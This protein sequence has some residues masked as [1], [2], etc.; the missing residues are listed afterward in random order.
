MADIPAEEPCKPNK[1][2]KDN[3]IM[4]KDKLIQAIR[5]KRLL[6][7]AE[8]LRRGHN[9]DEIN[10]EKESSRL[11]WMLLSPENN[12]RINFE[13]LIMFVGFMDLFTNIY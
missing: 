11:E 5:L 6:S 12:K 1:S 7:G 2:A 9:K 13:Y 10:F 8:K 3:W 4:F